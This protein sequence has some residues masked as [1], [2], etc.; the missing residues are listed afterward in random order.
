MFFLC[1]YFEN[2]G[3]ASEE[4][5]VGRF[6]ITQDRSDLDKNFQLVFK[7]SE[8]SFV[9]I[10][11][12]CKQIIYDLLNKKIFV[13]EETNK[14]YFTFKKIVIINLIT[15]RALNFVYTF[16]LHIHSLLLLLVWFSKAIIL[17]SVVLYRSWF[18]RCIISCFFSFGFLY[19]RV[20]IVS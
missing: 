12:S 9:G 17:L 18:N 15:K 19:K 4:V 10:S 13:K 3:I 14:D 2:D 11:E 8:T 20:N 5:L 16:Y 6:E 7:N 1:G